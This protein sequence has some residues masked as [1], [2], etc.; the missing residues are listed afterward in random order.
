MTVAVYEYEVPEDLPEEQRTAERDRRQ[1]LPSNF[2]K[3]PENDR[4][5]EQRRK[6]IDIPEK[7]GTPV[8]VLTY[9]NGMTFYVHRDGRDWDACRRLTEWLEEQLHK[10][11]AF[12][13]LPASSMPELGNVSIP[14]QTIQELLNIHDEVVKSPLAVPSGQGRRFAVHGP[15]KR[16]K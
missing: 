2:W 5:K 15:G 4:R 8:T 14:I 10:D 7:E 9:R 12:V 3:Q 16:R 6:V 13:S 1:A 11:V